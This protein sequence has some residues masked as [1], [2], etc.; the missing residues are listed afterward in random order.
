VEYRDSTVSMYHQ[1][2]R[3]YFVIP[4][5][6]W[7][8]FSERQFFCVYVTL[9]GKVNWFDQ[10]LRKCCLMKHVTEG[11]TEGKIEGAEIRER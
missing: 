7:V 8:I 11:T 2:I 3:N 10:V 1:V 4:V 9:F 5:M 6:H